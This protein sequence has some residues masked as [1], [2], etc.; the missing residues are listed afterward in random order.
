MARTPD[1]RAYAAA[2]ALVSPGGARGRGCEPAGSPARVPEGRLTRR[3]PDSS[4]CVLASL[5]RPKHLNASPRYSR[6]PLGV[7]E[8]EHAG[9]R[10]DGVAIARAAPGP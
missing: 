2:T 4:K 8:W 1:S 3:V 7:G 6:V 10:Q 5:P 9:Q